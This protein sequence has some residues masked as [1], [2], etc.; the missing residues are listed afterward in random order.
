MLTS[1]L[2][3]QV[4]SEDTWIFSLWIDYLYLLE[5]YL[6][7]LWFFWTRII[8]FYCGIA[9]CRCELYFTLLLGTNDFVPKKDKPCPLLKEIF[10]G[11]IL[12]W[13]S[14]YLNQFAPLHTKRFDFIFLSLPNQLIFVE[15]LRD[16][17]NTYVHF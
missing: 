11:K 3:V 16:T 13:K 10:N 17:L 12:N 5:N 9:N 7:I 2:K 8:G 14:L 1:S 6:K 4:V 15:T